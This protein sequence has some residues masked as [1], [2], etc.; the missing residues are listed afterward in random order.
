MGVVSKTQE[1][2]QTIWLS[3]HHKDLSKKFQN[4]VFGAL[5]N[6]LKVGDFWTNIPNYEQRA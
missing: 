6:S 1:T 5:H 2:D 3:R 4:F